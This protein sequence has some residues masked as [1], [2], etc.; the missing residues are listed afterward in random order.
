MAVAANSEIVEMKLLRLLE[1]GRDHFGINFGAGDTA[2]EFAKYA[3]DPVGFGEQVLGDT[4]TDEVKELMR[5]IVEHEVTVAISAN[6]TGKTHCAARIAAWW[7][8]VFPGAQVYTA[9]A[10]PEGNLKRLLWGEIGVVVSSHPEIF[11]AD[12]ITNLNIQRSDREFIAGVSIP[13]SGTPQHREAKF[14]GKH[15][16]YLL[17]ILDEGDAIPDEVFTG[18]ESCMSGGHA[19]LLVMFNPRKKQGAAYRM[20]RDRQAH[21]V[22]LTAFSHPNVVTGDDLIPGAVTREKT[23]KRINMWCRPLASGEIDD[24]AFDLP[25]FLVGCSHK[26]YPAPLKAGKYRVVHPMFSYMVLGEYPAQGSMQLISEEWYN[27]ARARYDA[28][29]VQHGEKPPEGVRPAMGF[30]VAEYG[31]DSNCVAF[32]YGGLVLPLTT[33]N[34]ID[35]NASAE[36]GAQLYHQRSARIAKVDALG[37]GSGV[38]PVMVKHKCVAVPVKVS[39]KATKKCDLGGGAVLEFGILRDQ[40]WWETREWLRMPENSAMLPPDE[41]LRDELLC[42]EYWEDQRTGRIKVTDK[43]AMKELLKRSPDRAE[44]V[45]LTHAP[46]DDGEYDWS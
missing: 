23:V 31:D 38:A 12:T 20:I 39:E 40:L 14:S 27:A 2:P 5:S 21:V 25:S 26:D 41:D 16:P 19:R 36:R 44:A 8:K 13:T 45:I 6:S 24:Q 7:Y 10:P 32:R 28:Y 46:E 22:K 15:A 4:Y 17:F 35:T 34:G 3:K 30:D 18:I 33:W 43:D 9:A 11:K 29:I 37:V 42:P 1:I